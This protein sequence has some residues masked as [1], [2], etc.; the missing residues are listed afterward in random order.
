MA[1]Y[2]E[3][4]TDI[5]SQYFL[6]LAPDFSVLDIVEKHMLENNKTGE[7]QLFYY[8]QSSSAIDCTFKRGLFKVKNA[9]SASIIDTN[10][11]YYSTVINGDLYLIAINN[12]D[13]VYFKFNN[14]YEIV[15]VAF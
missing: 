6:K 14:G 8:V 12:L 9:V 4:K 1:D 7:Y 5:S 13:K 15:G 10:A 2:N 11:A 3:F